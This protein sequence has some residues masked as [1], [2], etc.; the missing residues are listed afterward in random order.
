MHASAWFALIFLVAVSLHRMAE[1]FKRRGTVAGER[2]MAWSFVVFFW[3]HVLI[4]IGSFVECWQLRPVLN[5]WLSL[6][7]VLLYLAAVL[8]RHTAILALGRFWS[9]HLEIREGH[10]LVREGIYGWVRHPIY[11]AIVLEIIGIPMAVNAWWTLLIGSLVYLPILA[12]RLH[13]EEQAMVQKLG[14]Q[15]RTYQREVGALLP[16]WAAFSLRGSR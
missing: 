11:A 2:R 4:N 9:L 16:R 3:L 6:A 5:W 10:E 14:D 13:Q 12:M 7:G 15:Y 1:G 8:V